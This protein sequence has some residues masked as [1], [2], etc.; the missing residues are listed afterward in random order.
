MGTCER[1]GAANHGAQPPQFL[2]ELLAVPGV[3]VDSQLPG[4]GAAADV[5]AWYICMHR[6]VW[7]NLAYFLFSFLLLNLSVLKVVAF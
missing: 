5:G 4:I 1:S 2:A 6:R 3:R 7:R